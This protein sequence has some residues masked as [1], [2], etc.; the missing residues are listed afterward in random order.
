MNEFCS[1]E[2]YLSD[3]SKEGKHGQTVLHAAIEQNRLDIVI[4]L[5][6]NGANVNSKDARGG[7]PI[8]IAAMQNRIDAIKFLIRKGANVNARNDY[9][10]TPLHYAAFNNSTGAIRLLL[11]RKAKV[12]QKNRS[13]ATPLHV[14]AVY[15]HPLSARLLISRNADKNARTMDNETPLHLVAL[16][17]GDGV[18]LEFEKKYHWSDEIPKYVVKDSRIETCRLLVNSGANLKLID[19]TGKTAFQVATQVANENEGNSE[20]KANQECA[21]IIHKSQMR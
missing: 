8:H 4:Y 1:N 6:K 17:K 2:N 15:A 5:L 21:K 11:D 20:Y 13:G 16:A 12:N 3:K 7:E 10:D 19:S 18:I 14:A 9:A